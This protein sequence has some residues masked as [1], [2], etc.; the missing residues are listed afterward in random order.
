MQHPLRAPSFHEVL[1]C[2]KNLP[3]LV[4]QAI[5]LYWSKVVHGM[6]LGD[7]GLD[8]GL[9]LSE[10][11]HQ[12]SK[13]RQGPQNLLLVPETQKK[14]CVDKGSLILGRMTRQDKL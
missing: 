11:C 13:T 8:L 3:Q 14:A 1:S 7:F 12:T 10:Y 5:L 6:G 4:V 2:V 9:L